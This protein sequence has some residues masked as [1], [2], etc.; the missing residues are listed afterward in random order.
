MTQPDRRYADHIDTLTALITY[1]ALTDRK[2]RPSGPLADALSLPRENV[3]EVLDGFPSIFR[4]SNRV[5]STGNHFYTI[6]ARFALRP[7]DGG[8]EDDLPQVRADILKVLLEFVTENAR[9]ERAQRDLTSQLRNSTTNAYLAII[10]AFI[11]A[12]IALIG[13]LVK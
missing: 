12:V 10:G 1:L 13:A 5:D 6:H 11:V 9:A 2:S 8:D 3:L 4:K 7:Y